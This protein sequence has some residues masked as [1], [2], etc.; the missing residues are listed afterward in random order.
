MAC[1]YS[2]L[3]PQHFSVMVFKLT[4]EDNIHDC[5]CASATVQYMMELGPNPKVLIANLES[6]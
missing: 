3:G 2:F 6:L 4:K 5:L 1:P